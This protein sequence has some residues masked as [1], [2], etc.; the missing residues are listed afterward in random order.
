LQDSSEG[1]YIA[2]KHGTKEKGVTGAV[3]HIY[4]KILAEFDDVSK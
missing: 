2:Y 3:F 1:Y 4:R